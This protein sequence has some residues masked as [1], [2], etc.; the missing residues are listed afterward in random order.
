MNIQNPKNIIHHIF[1]SNI[2]TIIS[3]SKYGYATDI[4]KTIQSNNYLFER[5]NAQI[6]YIY[7]YRL[8]PCPTLLVYCS[9]QVIHSSSNGYLF[10]TC[11]NHRN[12]S[13]HDNNF[14]LRLGSS[15]FFKVCLEAKGLEK[16]E[17][18]KILFLFKIAYQRDFSSFNP[19]QFTYS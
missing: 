13:S 19:L 18:A 6:I 15:L 7:I 11:A 2:Q 17:E 9:S 14:T 4:K 12:N 5:S 3:G 16:N 10:S 8:H 1:V